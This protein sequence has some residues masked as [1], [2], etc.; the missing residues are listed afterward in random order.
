M[1]SHRLY[2]MYFEVIYTTYT[3][4]VTGYYTYDEYTMY[5]RLLHVQRLIS[6][7]VLLTRSI[8]QA[9]L[10]PKLCCNMLRNQTSC[11]VTAPAIDGKKLK[12]YYTRPCN[13]IHTWMHRMKHL[14][15]IKCTSSCEGCGGGG[16]GAHSGVGWD[17]CT[18]SV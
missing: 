5:T 16:R 9:A 2:T 4:C 10:S 1:C 12:D 18:C 11:W 7:L 14:P 13:D 3:I 6:F 8:L 15:A 17:T